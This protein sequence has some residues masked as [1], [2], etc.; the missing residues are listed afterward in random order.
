MSELEYFGLVPFGD[1]A[2]GNAVAVEVGDL[3]AEFPV[4]V[5]WHSP[6]GARVSPQTV[7]E[8]QEM[9]EYFQEGAAA[10]DRISDG[11]SG[12]EFAGHLLAAVRLV[13]GAEASR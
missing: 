3:G 11:S 4:V 6:T 2:H 10:P 8:A 7:A 13:T 5:I 9:A 1:P 12:V